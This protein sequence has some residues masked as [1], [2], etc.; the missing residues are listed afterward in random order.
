V[1]LFYFNFQE[2]KKKNRM[3]L[4]SPSSASLSTVFFLNSKVVNHALIKLLVT[5]SQIVALRLHDSLLHGLHT[6]H[7]A[8]IHRSVAATADALVL[9]F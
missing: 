1:F 9:H 8:N 6:H 3:L 4:V 7:V 2:K 5:P